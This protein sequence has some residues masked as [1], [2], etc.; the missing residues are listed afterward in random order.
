MSLVT[1]INSDTRWPENRGWW[2]KQLLDAFKKVKDWAFFK[3]GR[4]GV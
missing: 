4:L 3:A 1:T 2:R